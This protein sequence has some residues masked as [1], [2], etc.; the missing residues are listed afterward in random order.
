[1]DVVKPLVL[2]KNGKQRMGKGFSLNELKKVGLNQ[3]Q[4][5][6]L[7]IPIDPRRRTAHEDNVEKLKTLL[8]TKKPERKEKPKQKV[9]QKKEKAKRGRKEKSKT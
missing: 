3:K 9:E 6:K 7:G 1:M 4:A 5:L 2:K 8:E